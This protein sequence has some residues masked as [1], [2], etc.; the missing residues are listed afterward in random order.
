MDI[1]HQRIAH[2]YVGALQ[3]L[4]EAVT[5]IEIDDLDTNYDIKQLCKDCKLANA[6]QQIS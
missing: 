2:T 5:G 4:P 1:W 6:L 3:H